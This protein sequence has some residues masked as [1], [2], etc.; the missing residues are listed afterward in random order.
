[1]AIRKNEK[2]EK[3]MKKVLILT[4]F[5]TLIIAAGCASKVENR[6]ETSIEIPSQKFEQKKE[7]QDKSNIIERVKLKS[8]AQ[9]D[10]V[11]AQLIA[12]SV[13]KALIDG[14]ITTYVNNQE[15]KI[16]NGYGKIV[17]GKYL[18]SIPQSRINP[19]YEFYLSIEETGAVKVKAGENSQMAVQLF[20][21]PE[22]FEAPYDILN[23]STDSG[24]TTQ[25]K[26]DNGILSKLSS[27]GQIALKSK[28]QADISTAQVI[29]KSVIM[30]VQDE[31]IKDSIVDEELKMDSDN[32]KIL[33]NK[34]LGSL[35]YSKVNEKYKFY[36]TYEKENGNI[37]VKAGE[38]PNTAVQIYPRPRIPKP[39]YD[40]ANY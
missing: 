20:P 1:M 27:L 7:S 12:S 38:T 29:A 6:E 28:A 34:Y 16:N 39:P 10:V 13:M 25:N 33:I 30:A 23:E 8:S 24:S 17:I 9:T 19:D 35:P 26:R 2:G 37:F 21:R 31:Y 4:V 18:E 14:E 3:R 22:K 36:F 32:G 15:L 5:T 40:V 11:N